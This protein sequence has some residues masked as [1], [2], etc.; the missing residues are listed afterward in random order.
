MTRALHLPITLAYAKGAYTVSLCIG[1]GQ[2]PGNFV[3]DTGSSTLV[4]LP[5]VYDPNHDESHQPTSCAQQVRYGV[6]TWAG[7]VLSA[8]VHFDGRHGSVRL[9]AAQFS[10]IE[11]K[12]Q[13]LRDA[14]GLFGLAYSCLNTAHD[15]RDY[16]HER[17]IDP[18]LTWPW[19]FDREDESLADFGTLLKQQ[20]RVTITPLFTA[21]A[22]TGRIDNRFALLVRRPLLHVEDDS[23]DLALLTA[24]PRNQGV[25]VLGGSEHH[26]EDHGYRLHE[27]E[28]STIQLVDD[29]YYNANLIAVQVGD[30]PRIAAPPLDPKFQHRAA[31]NAI[32]DTGCSFVIL[33]ASLYAAVIA[34][35]AQHD[36]RLPA[37]AERFQ[38]AFAQQQGIANADVDALAWPALHFY[39]QAP[40]G[41]ETRLTCTDEHYWPRNAMR[42]G[43]A[44]FL[45]MNQL[46][47]WPNQTILGLP[48]LSERYCVFDRSAGAA[49]CIRVAKAR[50]ADAAWSS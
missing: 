14:D 22:E 41:S 18:P 1:R 24:D 7:P 12:A 4:V 2:H 25:L 43:Q 30:G 39:L 31:S 8:E 23:A 47:N 32:I 44:W 42:A 37:V 6:G 11:A 27:G 10:R 19:P 13:D 20:P 21:L 36:A 46:P 28:F 49:G 33:E 29:V 48:F 34:A 40:D 15:V 17:G 9:D 5:H 26:E 45:L 35:F 38:Q 3:L 16:L 50:G